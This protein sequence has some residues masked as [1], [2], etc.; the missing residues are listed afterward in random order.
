M[1]SARL[2]CQIWR[3]RHRRLRSLQRT[4]FKCELNVGIEGRAS[5]DYVNAY[6]RL[7]VSKVVRSLKLRANLA[8]KYSLRA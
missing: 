6:G 5:E 7:T 8:V 2:G 1:R 3:L 4:R